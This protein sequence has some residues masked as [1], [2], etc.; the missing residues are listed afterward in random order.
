MNDTHFPS[1]RW[2]SVP[3]HNLLW[4]NNAEAEGVALWEPPGLNASSTDN[5]EMSKEC[6][7]CLTGSLQNRYPHINRRLIAQLVQ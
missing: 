5:L 4:L 6:A 7:Y 3:I 1:A 2:Q